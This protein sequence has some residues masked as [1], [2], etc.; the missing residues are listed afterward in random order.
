MTGSYKMKKYI[1]ALK[2]YIALLLI[3]CLIITANISAAPSGGRGGGGGGSGGGSDGESGDTPDYKE[4]VILYR[5]ENGVPIPTEP[6]LVIDPETGLE[7]WGG[8]CRQPIAFNVS[9]DFDTMCP[10]SCAVKIGGKDV[11]SS[12]DQ[13][14]CAVAAECTGCTQ[15]VDFGRINVARSGSSVFESQLDD[16]IV[17][18]ST[19]D[20]VTLDPAGRLVA[21]TVENGI[22]P[23]TPIVVTSTIDSPIQNLAIYRQLM[24]T[25]DIGVGLPEGVDVLN[26]AARGIGTASGKSGEVNVDL[27]VYLNQIFGLTEVDDTI[28]G[29]LYED[30]REEVKGNMETVTKVF[31]D[32]GDYRYARLDNFSSE[33]KSLPRPAYIL[34]D[35]SFGFFEYLAVTPD[36][37]DRFFIKKGSILEAVFCNNFDE[38]GHCVADMADSTT[39]EGIAAGFTGGNI[40]GFAQSA[41]DTRA[42]INFM[43]NWPMPLDYATP[44][45]CV[46]SSNITYD[47]SISNESGLQ[48][49]VRMIDG[50]EEGRE[51]IVSI[52]NAGPDAASGTVTV[53][54]EET[55]GRTINGSPWIFEFTDLGANRS[56]SFTQIFIIDLGYATTINWTATVASADDANPNNNDVTAT[57]SIK[58]T[59]GGGRK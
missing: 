53:S 35:T 15:E 17:S 11:V 4:L 8:L 21:N 55:N 54:A 12:I 33:A 37:L 47:L 42:V 7:V 13:Y 18:L 3:T 9:N 10:T 27:I 6:Q 56:E 24:L 20:C 31:L 34:G 45:S 1:F 49:P 38:N 59:Q 40:G 36:N 48:V 25:G 2:S 39:G 28:L 44:V 14:S 46:A 29:K 50:M 52:A 26:T 30:Y 41:D 23:T 43:H 32:F 22:D 19:A 5:D 51:F 16:V 57:T 58:V